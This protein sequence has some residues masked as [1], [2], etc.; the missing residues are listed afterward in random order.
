M[1]VLKCVRKGFWNCAC[2]VGACG[3]FWGVRC[4]IPLLHTFLN[5]RT[6]FLPCSFTGS[7]PIIYLHILAV[8]NILCQTKTWF[9][10]SRI[11]FCASTK[12]FEEAL[13]AVKFLDWLKIFG[14][15]QNIL[16]PVKGQGIPVLEHLFL[17]WNVL[18]LFW[19]VLF[20]F[21]NVPSYFKMANFNL[22]HP[23]ICW[24]KC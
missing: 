4:L 24:K 7:K 15:A 1:C 20:L 18:F 14:P 21:W 13:N 5:K 12:F 8:S 6:R 2:D 9:A 23:K 16:G 3:W 11:G 10:F 22:E 19:N 17:F